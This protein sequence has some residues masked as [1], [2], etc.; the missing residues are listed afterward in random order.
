VNFLSFAYGF[1][2]H[3]D[4]KKESKPTLICTVTLHD[5][6]PEDVYKREQNQFLPA[7]KKSNNRQSTTIKKTQL[8]KT[9]DTLK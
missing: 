2:Y 6:K 8:N 5:F 4:N 7:L 9:K 3:G 1:G